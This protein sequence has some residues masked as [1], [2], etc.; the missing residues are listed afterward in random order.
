[1]L[2]VYNEA[3]RAIDRFC[4]DSLNNKDPHTLEVIRARLNCDHLNCDPN[5]FAPVAC[6]NFHGRLPHVKYNA[7][8]DLHKHAPY[9]CRRMRTGQEVVLAESTQHTRREPSQSITADR[10]LARLPDTPSVL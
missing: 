3:E 7:M 6:M 4:P 1:M 9:T 2:A 10:L 8:T 5:G